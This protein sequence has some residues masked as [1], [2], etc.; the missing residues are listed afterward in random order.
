MK[1]LKDFFSKTVVISG[2]IVFG[3]L[4]I[5]FVSLAS[6][7]FPPSEIIP[8]VESKVTI[9]AYSTLTPE[10]STNDQISPITPSPDPNNIIFAKGFKVNIYGTEGEGLRLHQS[11][12]QESPTVYLANEGGLYIITE[13]PII[14]GGYVWWQ[15]RS[16]T[17][18]TNFG[19]AVQDFLQVNILNQ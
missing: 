2:I 14:T 19:W 12:G 7:F 9:I 5:G 8:N 10:I 3:F 6:L 13:G 4:L 16:L 15:I 17:N 1:I 11:A 18:E